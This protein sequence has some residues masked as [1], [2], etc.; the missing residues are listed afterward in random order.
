[1]KMG[2]FRY[3]LSS[4]AGKYDC[5]ACGQQKRFTRYFDTYTGMPLAY[6]VGICDRINSCGYHKRPGEHLKPQN[7]QEAIKNMKPSVQAMKPMSCISNS[8]V[9]E[10][11]NSFDSNNFVLFLNDVIG[12]EDTDRLIERYLIGT[13]EH[14]PGATIFWQV[15]INGKVRTGKVMLYDVATGKRFRDGRHNPTWVHKVE[16]LPDF[17]LKQCL[18]GEHLL[19]AEQN[20]TVCI[21]ESE[22]TAIIAS[23]FIPGSVWLACGSVTNLSERIC[24]SL[25][26]RKVVLYPDLKCLDKWQ[27]KA[28]ELSHIATFS[29][30]ELLESRAT[31]IDKEKGFDIADYLLEGFLSEK[32]NKLFA[33]I[34]AET[35]DISALFA[36]GR[37]SHEEYLKFTIETE[38]KLKVNNISLKDF[39]NATLSRSPKEDVFVGQCLL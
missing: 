25:V 21:V 18:F 37:K 19:R 9:Q 4:K 22:K 33:S 34:V 2:D 35:V 26:G 3:T 11:L 30:S 14:W 28:R 5:P 36:T 13:S 17:N 6:D 1:M 32:R 29:V 12:H 20:K 23:H 8:I 16:K 15:D 38:R 31:D 7:Q 39:V 24:Q 10:S 27:K